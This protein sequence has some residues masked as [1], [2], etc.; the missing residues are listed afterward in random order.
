MITTSW[1]I[2]EI[3][4]FCTSFSSCPLFLFFTSPCGCKPPGSAPD[5][6]ENICCGQTAVLHFRISRWAR[7]HFFPLTNIG[8]ETSVNRWIMF[9]KLNKLPSMNIC[10]ALIKNIRS[11]SC[12]MPS[13]LPRHYERASNPRDLAARHVHVTCS[14]LHEFYLYPWMYNK[15]R[16]YDYMNTFVTFR[17]L[18]SW[19]ILSS[20]ASEQLS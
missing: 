5:S 9:F 3:A 17:S 10:I 6:E 8:K 14:V 4:V 11:S 15:S 16:L 7:K 12:K 19:A 20:C 1:A 2:P 18:K 13:Y